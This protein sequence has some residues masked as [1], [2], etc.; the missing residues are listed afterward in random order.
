MKLF[1]IFSVS[2]VC[3]VTSVFALTKEEFI[4]RLQETHPFFKEQNLNAAIQQKNQRSYL[5]DTDWLLGLNASSLNSHLEDSIE[6]QNT[7]LESINQKSQGASV[8]R[9]FFS[10]GGDLTLGYQ[11]TDTKTDLRNGESSSLTKNEISIF[12]RQ[13]LIRNFGGIV[14]RSDYDLAG[15]SVDITKLQS[16]EAKENFLL[17]QLFL[18]LDW[19]LLEAEYKITNDR[20]NL[21]KKELAVT[22]RKYK[23]SFSLKVDLITQ[24]TAESD[25]QLALLFKKSELAD[26]RE[27]LAALFQDKSFLNSETPEIN[28]YSLDFSV[29]EN[30]EN[31]LKKNS[32]VLKMIDYQKQQNQR[33]QKTYQNK[34]QIQLDLSLSAFQQDEKTDSTS[35][36]ASNYQ[37]GLQF[38]LPLGNTQAKSQLVESSLQLQQLNYSYDSEFRN[39]LASLRGLEA[40][41]K[42]LVDTLVLNTNQISLAS[43]RTTE[44]TRRYRLGHGSSALVLQAQDNEQ[45]AKIG[46]AQI[47]VS[48]QKIALQYLALLDKLLIQKIY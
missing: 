33:K 39:L 20:L 36:A 11:S 30:L 48:Y 35:G 8:N 21:I 47:A 37:I 34:K 46:Y 10:T 14:G 29:Q 38:S 43:Q 32:R 13:P 7:T 45:S 19:A 2:L 23:A 27:Q 18:F 26:V 44:E 16:L 3:T 1:F 9:S 28:I 12:Y 31:Y 5:G 24:E 4:K 17:Q 6:S 25:L 15:Y 42:I 41:F 40:R 22:R